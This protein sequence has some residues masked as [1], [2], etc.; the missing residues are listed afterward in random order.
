MLLTVEDLHWA[1]PS[2]LE[3]LRQLVEGTPPA[4]CHLFTLL[5]ARPEFHAPWNSPRCSTLQLERLAVREAK[6]LVTNVAGGELPD[7]VL[8]ELRIKADGVP[9]FVE[10]MTKSVME[11][12]LVRADG[13]RFEVARH[14]SASAVPE[15]LQD[16]LM[17]RLDRL[18]EGK[19]VAQ[20]AAV[21]GREFSL[22][23][24]RAVSELAPDHLARVLDRLVEAQLVFLDE[25]DRGSAAIYVFKHALVQDTAYRSLL[26]AT[27]QQFH[28]KIAQALEQGW[29]EAARTQPELLAQHYSD[30][31]MPREGIGYWLIAGQ[32]ALGGFAHSEAI[33]HFRH[34]LEQLAGLP[35]SPERKRLEIELRAGVGL[36]YL[37]TKGF[38]AREVEEEYG[39]ARDL[40]DEI[41]DTPVRVIY[42]IWVVDFVRCNR[43][44]IERVVKHFQRLLGSP[45]PAHV[46]IAKSALGTRCFYRGDYV[47]ADRLLTEAIGLIDRRDPRTQHSLLFGEHGY[48]CLLWAHGYLAWGMINTGQIDQGLA[49]WRD[50]TAM[51]DQIADRY[52][53]ATTFGFGAAIAHDVGD[54]DLALELA[55][56]EQAL[57]QESSFIFWLGQSAVICGWAR[58]KHGEPEAGIASI[59]QGLALFRMAGMSVRQA[60]YSSYLA[61][62]YL[63]LGRL[64]DGLALVEQ[65]LALTPSNVDLNHEPE[66]LRLK[67]ELLAARGDLEGAEQTLRQAT[68][69]A[70]AHGAA[71]F[72]VKAATGLAQLLTRRGRRADGVCQ[73]AAALARLPP[74]QTAT[75]IR[76]IQAAVDLLSELGA[77]AAS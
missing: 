31:G 76:P 73:L 70:E 45:D 42:G 7:D 55:L 43:G 44:G 68:G 65:L 57:A 14:L 22:E 24:L 30:A 23:L 48:D 63:M 47:G 6:T 49:L 35:G 51:A 59:E 27:R 74:G 17:A 52:V 36:G 29:T 40:C 50:M 69:L 13:N 64:D 46:L 32:R 1:D 75:A 58:A 66:L 19:A 11:S 18:G 16:S 33:S 60:Y 28:K 71:L 54:A 15:T 25:Q 34:G 12:G 5:T 67:G 56:K 2:T 20:L 38:A 39:R 53:R 4:G 3:L 41:G 9:L 37:A 61:E 77:Q 8:H 10:E 21:I 72:G 26:R 62:T